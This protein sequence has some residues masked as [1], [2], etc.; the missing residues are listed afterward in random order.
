MK[1]FNRYILF[2]TLTLLYPVIDVTFIQDSF[3]SSIPTNIKLNIFQSMKHV[4]TMKSTIHVGD[5]D[6]KTSIFCT[7]M[8]LQLFQYLENCF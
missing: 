7:I 1:F 6:I 3:E 4:S 5:T 2:T 8:Q